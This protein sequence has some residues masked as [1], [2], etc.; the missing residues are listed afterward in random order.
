MRTYSII[1]EPAE[2]GG[3]IVRVPALPEVG[4]Q[5]DSREEALANVRE[6]I[7]VAVETRIAAGGSVPPDC[8]P[9]VE[10]VSVAA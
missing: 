7:E 6:A 5:G 10:K 2:E 4:T 9:E 3:Y 8:P 1:L